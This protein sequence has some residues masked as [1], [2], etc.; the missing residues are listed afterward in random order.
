MAVIYWPSGMCQA[1]SQIPTYIFSNP[2]DNYTNSDNHF[3]LTNEETEAQRGL[4]IK[5]SISLSDAKAPIFSHYT[6][7]CLLFQ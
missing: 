1:L 5:V 6:R 7:I 4:I 3:L 2:Q